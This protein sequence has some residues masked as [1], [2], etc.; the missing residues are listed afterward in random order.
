M[1]ASTV[2]AEPHDNETVVGELRLVQPG[3]P[4]FALGLAV[5]YLVTKPAF[6]RLSF[7]SWSRILIGQINRGHYRFVVDGASRVQGFMGWALAAKNDAEDW[8][9]GRRSLSDAETKEGDSIIINA[10]AANNPEV[11]RLLLAECRSVGKGKDNVYFKRHY[12]DG[13]I[14][15]IRLKIR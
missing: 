11:H 15:P 8:L 3:N 9:T 4:V 12:N 7:G 6:A 13:T 1:Q 5:S 10:W 2:A 14:K